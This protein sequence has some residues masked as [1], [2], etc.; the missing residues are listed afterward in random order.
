MTGNVTDTAITL[1]NGVS[2]PQ[3]GL[4]VFQTPD[5][6]ATSQ[7]V[8]WAL[9]SG[10]RHIDTAM[11]YGNEQSV[12]EGLRRSGVD[13]RDVFLTTKLWNDDIRAGRAKEAFKESLDR[14]GVDYL[15]LYLI[16]WPA[17]G[18]Q[19]AWE[20]MEELHTISGTKPAV[21]QIESS[22]QFVNGDL[23]D[24]CHGI[25]RVDVEAYSPLGGTGGDLLADPRLKAIAERYDRSPAQ[26]VLRWHLQRGV[27]VIPK[28]TH[29]ERIEQ[30]AQVFDFELN[31]D[32][33]KT[34]TALNRDERTG[35][36]PDNFDF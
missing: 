30:N 26:I 22:P 2:I 34:I 23:I 25:L 9:Q 29:K 19:Q 17:K 24:Y 28:S 27:I 14:L 35:A 32:D 4:G 8:T 36:D 16:H 31:E 21:D 6:E 13:R 20:D 3:L 10:Y 11:I 15:D 1:N 18:W 12:G 33:M 7:A 5:G